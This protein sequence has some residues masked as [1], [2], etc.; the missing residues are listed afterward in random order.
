MSSRSGQSRPRRG[1]SRPA[2]SGSSKFGGG[3]KG[4]RDCMTPED[5]FGVLEHWLALEG[6]A[7]RVRMALRRQIRSQRD[8]ES[9]G[10]TLVSLHMSDHKTGLAGRLLL[11]FVK[12]NGDSLPMNR[13]KVGSPV[14]I[15]DWSDASDEGIPGVVSRR[16]H[17][18]IQ[19]ATEQWPAGSTFRIDLSPDETTRRRQLAAMAKAQTATARSGRLRDALLGFRPIR[20]TALPDVKFLTDLNPPQQDA[21]RFALSAQD[22][23]ILHGP[24]GT[25]K[26]PRSFTKPSLA[27]NECWRVRRATRRSTICWSVW[28]RSCPTCCG[29]GIRREY[30]SHCEGIRAMNS[31]MP[32]RRPRSFATC[33][34]NWNI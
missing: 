17:N 20:F 23:A 14:V 18:T 19:V 15:S 8:V 24:P 30:L 11:D 34:V 29:S 9:T 21:V 25:G 6:E 4:V 10:E 2:V 33:V 31:S 26:T 1:S 13:L 3:L 16:K 28:L 12:P 22:V 27:A 7:E 5:Y 32:I